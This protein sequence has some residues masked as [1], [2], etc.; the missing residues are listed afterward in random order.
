M[1]RS[2][3]MNSIDESKELLKDFMDLLEALFGERCEIVLHD[4]TRD[5][6]HTIVDIRNGHI[7]GR[8]V[9]ECMTNMGLKIMSGAL[10]AQNKF[11]YITSAPNGHILRS[12][13]IYFLDDQEKVVGSLC[14][15]LD[16]TDSVYFEKCLRDFNGVSNKNGPLS[17]TNEFFTQNVHTL[18]D[19]I[20]KQC[21]MKYGKSPKLLSKEEKIQ[22]ISD[23]DEKGAFIITKSSDR[24]SSLLGISRYTFYNYLDIARKNR[25]EHGADIEDI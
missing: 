11:N 19:Q 7:T 14:V 2:W 8:T 18:F 10:P 3:N 21:M 17:S 20:I 13:S 16:I 23:L 15:N 5:H 25:N 12:S 22:F 1:D 24:V 4:M 9:G 6:D